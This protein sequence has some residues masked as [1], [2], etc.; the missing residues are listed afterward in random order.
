MA[1][2]N[3]ISSRYFSGQGIVMLATR[4][5]NGNP[6]GFV[7][8]GNVS[9]LSI[10]Q[11]QTKVEHTESSTGNRSVDAVITTDTTVSVSMTL[12]AIHKENLALGMF[13]SATTVAAGA[14]TNES[15]K[16]YLGKTVALSKPNVSAVVVTD[17]GGVI[18]YILGSNYTIN[19][20]AGSIN[21]L[22]SAAQALATNPITEGQLLE[23]DYTFTAH[24]K[25][26]AFTTAAPERWL[27]FEG[28]NTADGNKPVIVN[29]YKFRFDPFAELALIN[30]EF[31]Q[32]VVEGEVL[33]D[34][35]K[36]SG[37][38]HYDVTVVA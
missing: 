1:Q 21:I 10:S 28:L 19:A 26:N 2:N 16:A 3:A 20:E 15:V 17:V 12:E 8:I 33:S 29:I 4:D 11:E 9:A 36:T 27:R 7:N 13:G 24:D 31:A 14:V 30:D 34:A 25:M 32:F 23:V 18:T 38:K 22:D 37:S 5:V 6:E 35:T